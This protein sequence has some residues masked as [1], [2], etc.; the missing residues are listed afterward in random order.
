MNMGFLAAIIAANAAAMKNRRER[1]EK[2]RKEKNMQDYK[3]EPKEN[4]GGD[5]RSDNE[6]KGNH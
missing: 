2:I 1:D 5:R 4:T 3:D 6:P